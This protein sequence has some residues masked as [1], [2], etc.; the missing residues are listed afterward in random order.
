MAKFILE[1]LLNGIKP[2]EI[3]EEFEYI[4][5]IGAFSSK[6]KAEKYANEIKNNT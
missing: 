6:E 5:Q 2:I 1:K 3:K 4:V